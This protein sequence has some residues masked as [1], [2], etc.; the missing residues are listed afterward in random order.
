MEKQL[1]LI[2]YR[3]LVDFV[4]LGELIDLINRKNIYIMA[5]MD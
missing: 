2:L 3:R 1:C 4:E 5:L